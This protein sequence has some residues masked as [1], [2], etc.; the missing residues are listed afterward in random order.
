MSGKSKTRR[1][2]KARAAAARGNQRAQADLQRRWHLTLAQQREVDSTYSRIAAELVAA[3][4]DKL[5]GI[6]ALAR[7]LDAQPVPTGG[8]VYYPI[9]LPGRLMEAAIAHST[10]FTD[11]REVYEPHCMMAWAEQMKAVD[12]TAG[13]HKPEGDAT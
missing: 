9:D 13:L 7:V 1:E 2:A 12:E 3:G 10:A 5:D 8:R 4:R 11:G 6:R